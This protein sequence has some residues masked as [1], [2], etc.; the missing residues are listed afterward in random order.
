MAR[1]VMKFGGTSVADIDRIRNVA[2]HVKREVDAGHEVAVVVSAMSGTTDRLVAWWEGGLKP[3]RICD[4]GEDDAVVATGEQVSAGLL[5]I[6][7]Q[8]LDI[9]ARSWQGWQLPIL[10]SD[11]HGS[12]RIV[13]ING[14]ELIRRFKERREVA[15]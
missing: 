10:T 14:E 7:L 8:D 1:L 9:N 11:A 15:V 4:T 6:T 12:A 13:E 3:G 5:A 2:H